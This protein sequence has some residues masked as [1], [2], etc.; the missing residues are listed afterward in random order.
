VSNS[1]S[2]W[3]FACA[4]LGC[5]LEAEAQQAPGEGPCADLRGVPVG[6]L[7][8]SL[9]EGELGRAQRACPVSEIAGGGGVLAVVEP[10]EFYGRLAASAVVRGS[11]AVSPA[12]E[13][14][15]RLEALRYDA[16]ISSLEADAFGLGH[17]TFGA[18]GRLYE[19][20]PVR[21]ALGGHLVLP[22]AYALYWNAWPIG[23]DALGLVEYRAHRLLR[24]HGGL[25]PLL[26][27]GVGQGPAQPRAAA[28][29]VAGA[30]FQPWRW[31]ALVFDVQT[32]FGYAA[33]LDVLALAPGL[34]F[35]GKRVGLEVSATLPVAGRERALLA[36]VLQIGGRL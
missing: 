21:L 3:L 32:Q 20:G 11:W 5:A 14:N 34:R 29:L 27:F 13:L 12:V 23:L 31:G 18:I 15:V 16:V 7:Y 6:P 30:R 22:T 17:V 2:A 25:G 4:L 9:L 19:T 10:E 8:A 33:A 28:S 24:V 1:R 26:Q 35:G 36:G